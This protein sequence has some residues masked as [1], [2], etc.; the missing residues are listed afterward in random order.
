MSCFERYNNL[1]NRTNIH[2]GALKLDMIKRI[3]AVNNEEIELTNVEFMDQLKALHD[4]YTK[5]YENT[6]QKDRET[7]WK[8]YIERNK[9]LLKLDSSKS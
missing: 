7:I 4:E 1:E 6:H 3:V 9:E 5:K 2:M 8:E